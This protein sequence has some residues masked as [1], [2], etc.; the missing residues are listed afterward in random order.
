MNENPT[1]FLHQQQSKAYAAAECHDKMF[2]KNTEISDFVLFR[3][4]II[5]YLLGLCQSKAYF[6][7]LNSHAPHTPA[8]ISAGSILPFAPSL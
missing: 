1:D 4:V 3:E 6:L 8:S 2:S 5:P 7:F